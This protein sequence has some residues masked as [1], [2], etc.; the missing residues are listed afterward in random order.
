MKNILIVSV[1][2]CVLA[3]GSFKLP[4]NIFK[5]AQLQKNNQSINQ[6]KIEKLGHQEIPEGTKFKT[7]PNNL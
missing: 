6:T 7:Q 1:F 3:V 2:F 4:K 5:K